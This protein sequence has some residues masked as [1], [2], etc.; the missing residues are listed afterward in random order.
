MQEIYNENKTEDLL[1]LKELMRNE[2]RCTTLDLEGAY[3][4][5]LINPLACEKKIEIYGHFFPQ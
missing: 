3:S 4:Y 2:T 5:N 1:S